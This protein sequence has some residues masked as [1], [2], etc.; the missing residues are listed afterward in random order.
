M[1]CHALRYYR[2]GLDLSLLKE[3]EKMKKVKLLPIIIA[4]AVVIVAGAIT[5]IAL[6]SKGTAEKSLFDLNSAAD[7]EQQGYKLS[8]NGSYQIIGTEEFGYTGDVDAAVEDDKLLSV[9]F[10]TNLIE[11][12]ELNAEESK[13][14]IE[15]FMVSFSEGAGFPQPDHP[16]VL[17]F[18][19]DEMYEACP[20]DPYQALVESYVLFE[21]SYRDEN[22]VIWLTQIFSPKDKT[23]T[24]LVMKCCD[25][26][27]FE[28][29]EPLV[30]LQEETESE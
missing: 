18:T 28:G 24:A 6:L 3:C 23:L 1:V 25:S 19:N 22:G 13:K 29:Y 2:N 4:A 10:R 11:G 14:K 21:Y 17:Q 12:E 16:S 27:G 5:L 15:K 7:F 20:E 26:S 8:V 30:N 9:C